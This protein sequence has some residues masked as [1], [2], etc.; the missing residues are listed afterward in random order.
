MQA[1]SGSESA[2]SGTLRISS[3]HRS[4][5]SRKRSGERR[6]CLR[7][8]LSESRTASLIFQEFLFLPDRT[9][10]VSSGSTR[11]GNW[12][13]H[14]RVLRGFDVQRFLVDEYSLFLTCSTKAPVAKSIWLCS[15]VL[16]ERMIRRALSIN[17][18]N[19]GRARSICTIASVV[20]V[21]KRLDHAL[22]PS[23]PFRHPKPEFLLRS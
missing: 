19:L 16:L 1:I 4:Q 18:A 21:Y 5:R 12:C 11:G 13:R 15:A 23:T 8:D 9:T 2:S 22:V 14:R 7:D 20:T 17:E 3:S 10:N 6:T